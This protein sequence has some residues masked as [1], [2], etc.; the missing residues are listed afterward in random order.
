MLTAISPAWIR[1]YDKS[2]KVLIGRELA[3]GES[4]TVPGDADQPMIR[5][6]RA[7]AIKVTVDGREVAPLG[8]A[9]RTIRDVGVSAA[10]L[11]ARTAASAP[12]AASPPAGNTTTQ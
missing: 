2:D 9:E 7:G 8:P 5:T 6:G 1:V 3:Q 4:W 11:A 10:A 12:G